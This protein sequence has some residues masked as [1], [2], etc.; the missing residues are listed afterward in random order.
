VKDFRPSK[1]SLLIIFTISISA[2][3]VANGFNEQVFANQEENLEKDTRAI[4]LTFTGNGGGHPDWGPLNTFMDK[5]EGTHHDSAWNKFHFPSDGAGINWLPFG[6][7]DCPTPCNWSE[8]KSDAKNYI[9]ANPL[10]KIVIAGFSFGGGASTFLG[11]DLSQSNRQVEGIF[12]TD[13]VG[14]GVLGNSRT[15][16]MQI[17]NT[18]G[19]SPIDSLCTRSLVRDCATHKD[20]AGNPFKLAQNSLIICGNDKFCPS[21]TDFNLIQT[22]CTLQPPCPSGTIASVVGEC[23]AIGSCPTGFKFVVGDGSVVKTCGKDVNQG[24]QKRCPS[25]TSLNLGIGPLCVRHAPC[26]AGT[27]PS[28]INECV[29]IGSSCPSPYK[30]VSPV[31]KT[32]GKDP[33]PGTPSNICSKTLINN[34]GTSSSWTRSFHNTER[35]ENIIKDCS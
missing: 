8:G 35:L 24:T 29:A 7:G 10:K 34:R 22:L 26:P 19:N 17:C 25:D 5:N 6:L 30:F 31:V 2:I 9:N 20:S 3:L 18:G 14:P 15:G 4:L 23:F 32:C 21:G 1:K 28:I 16:I 27:F 13:P 12:L 33:I 11:Y